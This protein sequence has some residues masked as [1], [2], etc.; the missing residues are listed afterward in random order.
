MKDLLVALYALRYY[1]MAWK[2]NQARRWWE[3]GVCVHHPAE[4]VEHNKASIDQWFA[5][6]ELLLPP[7]MEGKP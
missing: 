7:T 6:C 3:M 2:V 5:S 4:D 1:Q